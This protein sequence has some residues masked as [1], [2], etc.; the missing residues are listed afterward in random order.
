MAEDHST[1]TRPRD[2]K[3]A[4]W[5]LGEES[6]ERK[7]RGVDPAESG[8]DDEARALQGPL[9]FIICSR[10]GWASS[11]KEFSRRPYGRGARH[12]KGAPSFSI[13]LP[14]SAR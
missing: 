7:A 4:D 2:S 8:A 1:L 5:D 9:E 10:G 12:E 6:V 13:P 11:A 14:C 3:D